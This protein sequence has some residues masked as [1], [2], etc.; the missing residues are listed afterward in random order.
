MAFGLDAATPCVVTTPRPPWQISVTFLA[1]LRVI[2]GGLA[3][4]LN[5]PLRSGLC[6]RSELRLRPL[7]SKSNFSTSAVT[8]KSRPPLQRWFNAVP[9]GYS[10]VLVSSCWPIG[11]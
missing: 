9:R 2:N 3:V 6:Q 11:T 4:P 10:S 7:G 1:R 5:F 8:A